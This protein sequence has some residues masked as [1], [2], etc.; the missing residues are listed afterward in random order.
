MVRTSLRS[1]ILFCV[2]LVAGCS[3]APPQTGGGTDGGSTSGSDGGTQ[4]GKTGPVV[5]AF[6][7][8]TA[9]AQTATVDATGGTLTATGPGGT[10]YTLTVPAGALYTATDITLTPLTGVTVDGA[11]APW[12]VGAQLGPEGTLF[13]QPVTLE[14]KTGAAADV[15]AT[16]TQVDPTT[17]LFVPEADGRTGSSFTV[18]LHHFS[19]YVVAP[20]SANLVTRAAT[21]L[22]ANLAIPPTR[23]QVEALVRLWVRA[24]ALGLTAVSTRLRQSLQQAISD[25]NDAATSNTNP[26]ASDALGA[27][28][29]GQMISAAG[30]PS[31]GAAVSTAGTRIFATLM[32]LLQLQLQQARIYSDFLALVPPLHA[33]EAIAAAFPAVLQGGSVIDPSSLAAT[34]IDDIHTL[35]D[36]DCDAARYDAGTQKLDDLMQALPSLGITSPSAADVKADAATC[37]PPVVTGF[38][39][40]AQS[41]AAHAV[42][43][44]GTGATATSNDDVEPPSAST[45]GTSQQVSASASAPRATA[46]SSLSVNV[47][48]GNNTVSLSLSLQS[49]ATVNNLTESVYAYSSLGQGGSGADFSIDVDHMRGPSLVKVTWT[50]GTPSTSGQASAHLSGSAGG[51]NLWPSG[52]PDGSATSSLPGTGYAPGNQ[53]PPGSILVHLD[54]ATSVSQISAGQSGSATAQGT[55]TVQ[56]VPDPQ[57]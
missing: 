40:P 35:A 29:L 17:D 22:E 42:N 51:I 18:P 27:L 12:Q 44:P 25:F 14:V 52:T 30:H 36:Q 50:G 10:T 1:L 13:L 24:D 23:L 21:D 37:V 41:L 6:T 54:A 43:N 15:S 7:V 57:P 33:A 49:S 4:T 3:A 47:G 53:A 5:T 48:S 11:S 2:L 26:T 9:D 55:V 38:E 20:I 28:V 8:D 39:L 16:V 32:R 46:S 31:E 34:L 45:V 56:I 19:T